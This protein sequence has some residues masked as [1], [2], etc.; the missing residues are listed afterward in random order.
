MGTIVIASATAAAIGDVIVYNVITGQLSAVRPGA[1]YGSTNAL[2]PNSV[3]YQYPTTAAG[4]V[5][6]RLTN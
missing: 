5:A 6:A 1:A 2:L 4:L 3:I